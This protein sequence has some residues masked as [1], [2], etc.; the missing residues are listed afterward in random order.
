MDDCHKT[1]RIHS[2]GA[3]KRKSKVERN[4]QVEEVNSQIPKM[5]NYFSSLRQSA[6]VSK[7]K[8]K[9]MKLKL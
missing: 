9:I 3:Q 6:N 4:K 8:T 2:S 7:M 1:F 5:T